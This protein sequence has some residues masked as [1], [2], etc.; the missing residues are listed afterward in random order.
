LVS[1]RSFAVAMLQH[2]STL[3]AVESA[4]RA[5][6]L[7]K[8]SSMLDAHGHVQDASVMPP[9]VEDKELLHSY[10]TLRG[11]DFL[12][13]GGVG[14]YDV[15]LKNGPLEPPQAPVLESEA[16]DQAAQRLPR[17]STGWQPPKIH[18]LRSAKQVIADRMAKEGLKLNNEGGRVIAPAAAS[19]SQ[20]EHHQAAPARQSLQEQKAEIMKRM[21]RLEKRMG[22][23]ELSR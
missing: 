4:E 17:L 6:Q 12:K 20:V 11:L 21:Q 23:A 1:S 13:N 9:S 14:K 10:P 2:G 8:P 5:A 7:A 16:R 18:L 22:D 3:D 19:P 15:L